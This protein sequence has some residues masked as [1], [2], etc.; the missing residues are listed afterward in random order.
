[1]G[2]LLLGHWVQGCR[3][4]I[5]VKDLMHLMKKHVPKKD[6]SL[7]HCLRLGVIQPKAVLFQSS[8]ERGAR[9]S[10]CCC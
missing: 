1:M 5:C 7:N 4:G 6:M 3:Q 9:P 8:I 2:P 10:I